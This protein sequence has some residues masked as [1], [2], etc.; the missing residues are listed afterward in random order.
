MSVPETGVPPPERPASSSDPIPRGTASSRH[1]RRL[2]ELLR[3]AQA[4]G[5]D[6]RTTR[7]R[8]WQV[9][10][11][12]RPVRGAVRRDARDDRAHRGGDRRMIRRLASLGLLALARWPRRSPH[13]GRAATA[14]PRRRPAATPPPADRRAAVVRRRSGVRRSPPA[15]AADPHARPV[16]GRPGDD[17]IG[18]RGEPARLRA[19]QL[20]RR[21]AIRARADHVSARVHRARRHVRAR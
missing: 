15:P 10:L 13:R 1:G 21:V 14:R 5:D 18:V 17:R 11:I 4:R 16:G 12:G 19:H 20:S 7:I 3:G 6:E 2:L 9:I 8:P